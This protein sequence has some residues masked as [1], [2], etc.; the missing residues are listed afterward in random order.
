M[1]DAPSTPPPTPPRAGRAIRLVLQSVGFL[2][3][4]VLLGWCIRVALSDE[5]REQLARL[6]EASVGQVSLLLALSAGTLLINGLLFWITLRPVHKIRAIDHVAINAVCTFLAF[7]P[8]KIGTLSRVAI[9][10]RRDGVPLLTIGAWYGVMFA[11]MLAAYIPAMGASIWRRGLDTTWWIVCL[12]GAALLC[13]LMVGIARLFAGETGIARLHKIID[14]IRLPI[15]SRLARTEHFDRVHTAAAMA[16]SPLDMA[17]GIALRLLDLGVMSWRFVVAGSIV[18][19]A[20]GWEEA[21]LVASA[22]YIIGMLSPFGILGAREAGTVFMAGAL[23]IAASTGQSTEEVA[24]SLTV[25][26]LFITGTESI[27][28]LA[29][30]AAGTVWLRPDRL[31]R[32]APEETPLPEE[33][34]STPNH[35]NHPDSEPRTSVRADAPPTESTPD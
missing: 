24:P 8:F 19:V 17:G 29:G 13:A 2:I 33:T 25:L 23:G 9:N 35:P 21:V 12:G 27:V 7:L 28:L 16:A 15:V 34:P 18:G 26:T 6:R 3:G 20:F 1:T 22:Y 14:S 10:N 5:N 31:L 32:K 30:A 11:I 4:L